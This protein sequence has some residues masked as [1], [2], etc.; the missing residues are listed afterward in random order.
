M[1]DHR[2]YLSI[3]QNVVDQ[4]I[5]YAKKHKHAAILIHNRRRLFYNKLFPL[6]VS[7]MSYIIEFFFIVSLIVFIENRL[8]RAF[9]ETCTSD[10]PSCPEPLQCFN[11]YCLCSK[12]GKTTEPKTSIA[13][14]TGEE[15]IVCPMHYVTSGTKCVKLILGESN[16]LAWDP[17]RE[18]CQK[19]GGDL[20]VIREDHEV[21][22]KGIIE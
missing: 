3:S 10:E 8:V 1:T 16:Q 14:W 5:T 21:I 2:R 6:F 4:T 9:N 19:D 13:F 20:F 7:T 22:C 17:A 12:I 11:G 15:C 18:L